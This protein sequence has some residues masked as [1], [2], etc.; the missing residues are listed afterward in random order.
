MFSELESGASVTVDRRTLSNDERLGDAL[1]TGLRLNEGV[2][3]DLL[4]RRY[5]VDVWDRFAARLVPFCDGGHPV[6]TGGS[7][8]IDPAG[9]AAGQRGDVGLRLD[10]S[11]R[12]VP[13]NIKPP[14]DNKEE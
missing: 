2:D 11:L 5:G 3:L 14:F 13:V 4:S 12:G 10:L 8:P 9:D 1:F 7:P 6:E